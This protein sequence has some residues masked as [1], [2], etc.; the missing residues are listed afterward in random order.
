MKF[1]EFL[2]YSCLDGICM[3]GYLDLAKAMGATVKHSCWQVK[4]GKAEKEAKSD[5]RA[6][7][8]HNLIGNTTTQE[9]DED[10]V[11]WCYE[12]IGHTS[13][14]RT[15]YILYTIPMFQMQEVLRVLYT[16]S[17]DWASGVCEV[18]NE[19]GGLAHIPSLLPQPLTASLPF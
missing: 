4:G 1:Q 5:E 19:W 3:D 10:C 16:F 18:I 12:D 13:M 14:L 6:S 17:P 15:K 8:K 11:R 2:G 9:A 7:V